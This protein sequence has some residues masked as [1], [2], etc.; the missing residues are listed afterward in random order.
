[1]IPLQKD[2]ALPSADLKP[3]KP[4]PCDF[5]PEVT[6]FSTSAGQTE[7]LERFSSSPSLVL[8]AEL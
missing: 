7:R 1:M 5:G 8:Q 3:A 6:K 4:A 2:K